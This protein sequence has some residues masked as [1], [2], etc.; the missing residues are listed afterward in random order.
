M[1]RAGAAGFGPTGDFEADT[2]GCT[3]IVKL[4]SIEH[5]RTT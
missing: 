1:F 4:P 2:V 3:K 5:E